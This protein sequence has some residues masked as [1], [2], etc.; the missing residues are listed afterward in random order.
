MPSAQL[1]LP[2]WPAEVVDAL[3]K[4]LKLGEELARLVREKKVRMSAEDR[5]QMQVIAGDRNKSFREL[6]H[7]DFVRA[8]AAL[9]SLVN[10]Y[11][12]ANP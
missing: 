9:E 7:Q 6:R 2:G 5:K 11:R 10:R 8:V 1:R 4:E 3:E 12:N